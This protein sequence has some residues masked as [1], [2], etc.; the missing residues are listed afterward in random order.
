MLLDFCHGNMAFCLN[1]IGKY[2]FGP[3]P[4]KSQTLKPPCMK[5]PESQYQNHVFYYQFSK[6]K[7]LSKQRTVLG[8]VLWGA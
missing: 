8:Q 3:Y 1:A 4:F 7:V 6:I 2:R 5:N